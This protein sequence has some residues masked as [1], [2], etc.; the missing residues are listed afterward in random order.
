MP[1][2]AN[3][4]GV[5]LITIQRYGAVGLFVICTAPVFALL[6]YAFLG[7]PDEGP[8]RAAL[9][10]LAEPQAPTLYGAYIATTVSALWGSV[11]LPSLKVEESNHVRILPAGIAVLVYTGLVA[12]A[13]MLFLLLV[14]SDEAYRTLAGEMPAPGGGAQIKAYASWAVGASLTAF[15]AL[16]GVPPPAGARPPQPEEN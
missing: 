8:L 15:A 13:G 6:I 11:L 9:R 16:F 1:P 2:S 10:A 3:A 7:L 14:A 12:G 4:K 5:D